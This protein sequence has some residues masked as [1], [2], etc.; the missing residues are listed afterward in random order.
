M[1]KT[2][3]ERVAAHVISCRPVEEKVGCT[4]YQIV[5]KTP[6]DCTSYQSF[7]LMDAAQVSGN[8]INVD[9]T[10]TIYQIP[11]RHAH[12][13]KLLVPLKRKC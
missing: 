13:G 5:I 7:V 4:S 10:P 1:R 8:S 3:K 9:H 12:P 2:K 6:S 11:R